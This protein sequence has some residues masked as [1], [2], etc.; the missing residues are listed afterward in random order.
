MAQPAYELVDPAERGGKASTRAMKPP[1]PI[2]ADPVSRE[3]APAGA[4]QSFLRDDD[5]RL[6]LTREA[7]GG[8]ERS[9]MERERC[10]EAEKERG[11]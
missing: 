9:R 7:G 4:G 3:R 2:E 1:A 10:D 6:V 5:R 11:R 8:E